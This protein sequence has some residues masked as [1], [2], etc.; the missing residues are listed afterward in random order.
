MNKLL[1]VSLLFFFSL[2][3]E[4]C[5][6]SPFKRVT[7]E[8]DRFRDQSD[9]VFFGSLDT[10]EFDEKSKQQ[11]ARFTIIKSYKGDVSGQIIITNKLNSSCSRNFNVPQSAFYVYAKATEKPA[12]YRIT[13]FASF[14]PLEYALEHEWLP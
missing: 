13:G 3:S 12:V 11:T 5:P 10:E 8:S 4:A 14:V 6:V 1:L 9:I 7:M 2:V